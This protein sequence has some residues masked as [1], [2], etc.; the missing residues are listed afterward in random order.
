M[1]TSCKHGF[2]AYS[3]KAAQLIKKKEERDYNY[4]CQ[5]HNLLK[6]NYQNVLIFF[7][8]FFF[9]KT[10]FPKMSFSACFGS[11]FDS[12]LQLKLSISDF[13]MY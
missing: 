11:N 6:K 12:N 2:L 10:G 7:L 5:N 8:F 13:G 3:F 1:Q 4:S 9:R